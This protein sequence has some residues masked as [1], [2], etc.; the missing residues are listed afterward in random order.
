MGSPHA[1]QLMIIN[2]RHS[3]S[4]SIGCSGGHGTMLTASAAYA[5]LDM[6]SLEW[7]QQHQR[8]FLLSCWMLMHQ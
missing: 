1:E 2:R 6:H 4:R 3:S 8:V 7:Q 5:A